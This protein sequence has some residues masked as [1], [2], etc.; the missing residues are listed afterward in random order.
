MTVSLLPQESAAKKLG[1]SSRSNLILSQ[2]A[3]AA[4]F[5]KPRLRRS[6]FGPCD[7]TSYNA[8]DAAGQRVYSPKPS[9]KPRSS[10]DGAATAEISDPMQIE[11]VSQPDAHRSLAGI[12]R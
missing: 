1:K 3:F 8:G 9:M 2:D 12:G 5:G 10:H 7:Q 11:L 4:A 6:S